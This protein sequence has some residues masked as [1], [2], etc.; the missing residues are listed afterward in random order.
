M[1]YVFE[2][3]GNIL[4]CMMGSLG[5]LLLPAVLPWLRCMH[6]EEDLFRAGTIYMSSLLRIVIDSFLPCFNFSFY[7]TNCQAEHHSGADGNEVD[8]HCEYIWVTDRCDETW[9]DLIGKGDLLTFSTFMSRHWRSF[10]RSSVF[11]IILSVLSFSP[12]EFRHYYMPNRKNIFILKRMDSHWFSMRKY[13]KSI[14]YGLWILYFT[15]CC[16]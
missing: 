4:N 2:Q 8:F 10:C 16:V 14:W 13:C 15:R 3:W 11:N 12:M 7:D 9:T 1:S 5:W 6:I